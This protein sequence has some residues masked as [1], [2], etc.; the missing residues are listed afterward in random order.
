MA[1]ERHII[2][3]VYDVMF[4]VNWYC[5]WLFFSFHNW[6]YLYILLAFLH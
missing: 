1:D 5:H 6:P 4:N 2:L 3:L